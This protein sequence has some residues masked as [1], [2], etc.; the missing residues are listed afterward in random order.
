MHVIVGLG[1]PGEEYEWTRHN[2]G[3]IVLF[4][5]MRRNKF[6]EME[7]SKNAKALYAKGKVKN[8]LA[9]VLFPETFMNKSGQSVKYAI[10]KHNVKSEQVIVV[11]DD[12]DLP[13]GSMKISYG[14]GSG[15]HNGLTSIIKS[16]GTK[17]FIRIRIGISSKTSAGK[18]RKPKGE[19]KVL[20]FLLG[21]FKKPEQEKLKKIS[22]EASEAIE[23][24]I[25][26]GLPAAMNKFN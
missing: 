8:K 17:D 10:S 11:Y 1:N 9:E 6:P 24:V 5:F 20:D 3:R 22:K 21:D 15:G 13:L 4:E 12:I 25:N 2:T 19:K 23:T 7:E 14:R 26:K 16:I 18:V